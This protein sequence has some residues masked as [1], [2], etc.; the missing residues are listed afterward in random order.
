MN[1]FF[2]LFSLLQFI[3]VSDLRYKINIVWFLAI[4]PFSH[5]WENEQPSLFSL[6]F[7]YFYWYS[8]PTDN[9][10]KSSRRA[11][12]SSA[13]AR[14]SYLMFCIAREIET[15]LP[16]CEECATQINLSSLPCLMN[17]NR[18]KIEYEERWRQKKQEKIFLKPENTVWPSKIC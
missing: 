8:K 6:M 14:H 2:F 16:V 11:I 10:R 3:Y 15:E 7:L 4:T 1:S 12:L 5:F 18:V 17:T 13:R 9:D